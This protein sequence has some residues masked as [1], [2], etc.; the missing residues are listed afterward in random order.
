ML[1]T[2]IGFGAG[3]LAMA[4]VVYLTGAHFA[5]P[6]FFAGVVAVLAPAVALLSSVARLRS[7]ARFL[8]AFADSFEGSGVSRRQPRVISGKDKNQWGW[9]KPSAKQRDRDLEADIDWIKEEQAS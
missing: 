2:S 3:V 7:I 5:A 4:A 8:N 1:K 9:V 6:M